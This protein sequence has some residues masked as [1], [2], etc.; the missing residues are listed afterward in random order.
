M[1]VAAV[2]LVALAGAAATFAAATRPAPHRILSALA[3]SVAAVFL[4][5]VALLLPAFWSAQPNRAIV[6]DV[7]RE[8]D[9]KPEAEVVACA[10]PP[11]VE[12]DLLFHARVVVDTRCDLWSL[13][14]TRQPFLFL[15]RPQERASF[16]S[17]PGFREVGS[18]RYLPATV[19]T[20]DGLV[21]RPD[22][23]V[24]TLAAN[25]ETEDPVADAKR[26]KDR[27]K[28]LREEWGP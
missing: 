17:I 2:A 7:A 11:R 23:G 9:F 1:A 3:A 22:P 28:A 26:K 10:D 18:Y 8:R 27:K 21:S 20:L 19:L 13:A 6:A 14:P 4:A 25:F 24:M 16:T 15:L 12:R 5:I